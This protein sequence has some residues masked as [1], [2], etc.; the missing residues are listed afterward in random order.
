MVSLWQFVWGWFNYDI[1]N[2]LV[3]EAVRTTLVKTSLTV[4]YKYNWEHRHYVGNLIYDPLDESSVSF[5]VGL[6]HDLCMFTVGNLMQY[7]HKKQR[8]YFNKECLWIFNPTLYKQPLY[9]TTKVFE[10]MFLGTTKISHDTIDI[11]TLYSTQ[12][13]VVITKFDESFCYNGVPLFIF[14]RE[15]SSIK[16]IDILNFQ[17]CLH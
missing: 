3:S 12:Q 13:N 7:F 9:S 14:K 17:L 8:V 2:A 5:G 1:G 6:L 10:L 16:A 4:V 15:L 11:I